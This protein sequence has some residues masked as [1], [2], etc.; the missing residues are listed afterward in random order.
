M[1]KVTIRLPVNK[2]LIAYKELVKSFKTR[3]EAIKA[4]REKLKNITPLGLQMAEYSITDTKT[5]ISERPDL[6][7]I[8]GL[9]PKGRLEIKEISEVGGGSNV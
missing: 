2:E 4:L 5:G 9:D 6:N 1:F 3:N 7:V 8:I